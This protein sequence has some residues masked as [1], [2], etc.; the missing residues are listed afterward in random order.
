MHYPQGN[1]NISGIRFLIRNHGSR[2][3]WKKTVQNS[4]PSENIFRN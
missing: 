1:P 2:K 4:I 3:K